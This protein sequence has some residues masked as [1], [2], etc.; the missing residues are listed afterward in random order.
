ML[1]GGPLG[2]EP[3]IEALNGCEITWKAGKDLTVVTTKKTVK[4][5]G[6]RTTVTKTEPRPS[7]FRF[8]ESPDMD[9]EMDE[10]EEEEEEDNDVLQK[11]IALQQQIHADVMIAT[12][13]KD[14]LIPR[15]VD[16]FT[17]EAAADDS[18]DEDDDEDYED[19]EE[20]DEDEEEEEEEKPKKGGKGGKGRKDEEEDDDEDEDEGEDDAAVRA[21]LADSF[22]KGVKVTGKKDDKK[23]GG[24]G[25]GDKPQ[26]CKQQ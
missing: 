12:A 25:A 3:N 1:G 11:H 6:K 22:K 24:A 7:F 20:E 19:D 23:D 14:K 5:K 26:E 16:W 13:F 18:D 21:A 10:E 4:K 8:F 9:A 2:V 17:G 15:A